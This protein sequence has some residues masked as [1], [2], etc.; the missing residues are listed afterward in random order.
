[1]SKE[2]TIHLVVINRNSHMGQI[3]TYILSTC[4]STQ[5]VSKIPRN[6]SDGAFRPSR[7]AG[8]PNQPSQPS[9]WLGKISRSTRIYDT[10]RWYSSIFFISVVSKTC[11]PNYVYML[12]NVSDVF[13]HFE[14]T[15]A[16]YTPHTRWE[17][18]AMSLSSF[19]RLIINLRVTD[20]SFRMLTRQHAKH[21]YRSVICIE[22]V[23]TT[24]IINC[25]ANVT[26]V[27]SSRPTAYICAHVCG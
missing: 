21:V 9:K 2:A 18:G 13:A 6:I 4:T 22:W 8:M 12:C 15:I 11:R 25:N 16:I 14:N 20:G 19:V 10:T 23:P 5:Y 1:M 7:E 3:Q 24:F 27:I 26:S 17:T